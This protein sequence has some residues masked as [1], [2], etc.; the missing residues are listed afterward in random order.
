MARLAVIFAHKRSSLVG[1][2][3]K[4]DIDSKPSKHFSV[5]IDHDAR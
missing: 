2:C 1:V 5:T 4:G 3:R